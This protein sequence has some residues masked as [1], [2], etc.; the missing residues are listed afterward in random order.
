VRILC[1]AF[2]KALSNAEQLLDVNK[3]RRKIDLLTGEK[4]KT[5]AKDIV[6]QPLAVIDRVK[7]MMGN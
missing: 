4:L 2:T 3:T 7:N 6:I 1:I 5:V